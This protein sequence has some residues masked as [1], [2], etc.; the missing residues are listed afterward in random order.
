MQRSAGGEG[1]TVATLSEA[2]V[3]A[4]AGFTDL[5]VAYPV[6]PTG[7]KAER[8]RRLLDTI[9]LYVGVDSVA[10]A[11]AVAAAAQGRRT[12]VVIE[13]DSGQHRTGVEPSEVPGIAERCAT[14]GLEVAG[15]FT[16]GGHSYATP[17]APPEAATDEGDALARAHDALRSAGFEPRIVSAGSTP[18]TG[19]PR[20]GQV[21]E[22][23]PG[24]YVF[25][26]RQQAALGACA[27]EEVALFVAATVVSTHRDRFVIDAGSKALGTD[28][29]GWLSGHGSLPDL[30]GAEVTRLSEHH[31]V[32]DTESPSPA[33]GDVVLVTPNHVCNVVNLFDEY[34]VTQAGEVVDR[35]KVA[36]RGRNV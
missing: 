16:H 11:A 30:G 15:V 20:P 35:W 8:L 33:V 19:G 10:G 29:P 6:L 5:L 22:E 2:E 1:L 17:D 27:Q 21:T 32:V 34:L 25:F 28:R 13:V 7:A 3:F 12:R 31:G 23:R 4:S 9:T 14:L 24:S 18:T 36:A 26:D